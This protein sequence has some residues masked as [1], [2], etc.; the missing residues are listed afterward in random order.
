MITDSGGVSVA[1]VFLI[2]FVAVFVV[3][4]VSI[5]GVYALKQH[6]YRNS[7]ANFANSHYSTTSGAA[8][9]TDRLGE[10]RLGINN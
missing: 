5:L 3:L 6:R 10:L 4:G 2:A 9:F 7:F 1:W 8:I